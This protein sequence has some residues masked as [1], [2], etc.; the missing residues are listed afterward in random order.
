MGEKEKGK[1]KGQLG[2]AGQLEK[3]KLGNRKRKWGGW[4]DY[5]LFIF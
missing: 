4:D 1:I 5:K 3:R 2:Q